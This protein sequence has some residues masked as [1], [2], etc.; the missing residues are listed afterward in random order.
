MAPAVA[1]AVLGGVLAGWALLPPSLADALDTL[2]TATL[3]ALV[4]LVGVDLGASR[5]SWR[6]AAALGPRLLL[7][8]AAVAVGSLAGAALAGFILAMPVKEA[9]AVGAGF[10]WYSLSGVLIAGIH[11]VELGALAF[12]ANVA[13][14]IMAFLLIPLLA[15]A[16]GHLAAIA[17]GGATTMDST[18]PLITRVTD[19]RTAL[20]AFISGLV[21]TAAVPLLIPFILSL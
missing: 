12:L 5:D 8:P 16:L 17:P 10:G 2:V 20:V 14:E 6:Q 18:L 3:A 13:R 19:A 4:F 11:S 9:V 7:V 1:L 21:L 15:A